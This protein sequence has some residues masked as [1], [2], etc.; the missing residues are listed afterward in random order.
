M[1]H[2]HTRSCYTL[3]ESTLK[4]EQIIQ[5]ALDHN[6]NAVA[7]TEKNVMFSTMAFLHQAQKAGLKP[8]IGLEADVRM[9]ESIVSLILYARNNQGLSHLFELSSLLGLREQKV[10][11]KEEVLPYMEDLIVLTSGMDEQIDLMIE[12]GKNES[13]AELLEEIQEMNPDFFVS[14][15]LNDSSRQR[16]NNHFLKTIAQS[17]S[18]PTVALSRIDYLNDSDSETLRLLQAIGHQKNLQDPSL[19][20][21]A[22]RYWRTEE[23]M[24]SLYDP[25]DLQMT[26]TIAAMTNVSLPLERSDLP[27][28]ESESMGSASS[29]EYLRALCRAGLK[30][31]RNGQ[32]TPEYA[33]RLAYELDMIEKMGFSDYF[34]IVWDF[35]RYGRSQDILIGPGRGS[36]AGSLVSYCLGIT[37]ID[38][39]QANLLFERFLNPER[40]SMPDIDTDIPDDRRD[41]IIAYVASKYGNNHAAHIVTFATLKARMALR[42]TARALNIHVRVAD[43]LCSLLGNDPKITLES[44]YRNNRQFRSLVDSRNSLKQLFEQ[45]SRIEGL[46]RHISVHAGGIILSGKPISQFAPL[47]DAGMQIPA[48][49]FT[50]EYL[51]EI[52]LIKFDFLGLKNLSV[53]DA[54]NRKIEQIHGQRL[55]LLH[56]PLNDPKVYQLLRNAD[57]LGV[58]QLESD[59]IRQLIRQYQPER[60][61]DIAAILALYRPGPMKNIGLFLE[62]KR[63]RNSQNRRVLHPALQDLLQET[64]G[65]FLYQEQI[66]KAAQIIGG[67]SLAQADSLRKAM[68]KKDHRLMESY[69]KLFIEGAANQGIEE[70]KAVEIFEVME[71]FA[72]YGFNKSHSYVYALIVYQ[73]AYI[74]ANYPQVFY[75]CNLNSC[76]GSA[77]KTAAFLSEC[78]SRN[79]PV[80]GVDLN[81]SDE[82]YRIENGA[83]RMPFSILK[84]LGSMVSRKIIEERNIRGAFSDV[85]SAI[86][87][88][89][90][91]GISPNI[92]EVL[93]KAGA[94]DGFGISRT[95]MMAGMERLLQYGRMVRVDTDEVLFSFDAVSRPRIEQK[96]ESKMDR[97][98]MEKEVYGFYISEHPAKS[99]RRRFP[100][101]I[102][103]EQAARSTGIVEVIG[104]L[105]SIKSH[106]TKKNQEMAFGVLEDDSETIDLAIMPDLYAKSRTD[107]RLELMNLV[108]ITGKKDKDRNSILVNT[109]D[110]IH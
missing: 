2:L 6:Q 5:A 103:I 83:L 24:K 49:Q 68:S 31:R 45:A 66:M 17:L 99:L 44:A 71:R 80:Y 88:L 15:A 9:N 73:M 76:M 87:R 109:I 42:D 108:R 35:I 77:S 93:T 51:E 84:G 26:E 43:Q 98:L 39:I 29:S 81:L 41:E 63:N 79:L 20:V 1:I 89:L 33:N 107:G 82:E 75:L 110:I 48:V 8:V 90:A 18:I 11:E 97:A 69:R 105:K 50:M 101:A 85:F 12:K 95:G 106:M 60:F 70:S 64:G 37:H 4:I 56:L 52:G 59:G 22:H 65:V 53:I 40:I 27:V 94:F 67:F 91:A 25:E 55:D 21:R 54:M 23:E 30:K 58:F 13:L 72:D 61:E 14:I 96:P 102:S 104:L 38:P 100:K 16:A 78:R 92:I 3:L 34:L 36:A 86:A 47:I 7:L 32:V 62:A 28:F 19:R 74:K 10:L 57:T 46:P